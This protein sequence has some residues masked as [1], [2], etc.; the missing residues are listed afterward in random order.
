MDGRTRAAR[1]ET[2]VRETRTRRMC[3]LLDAAAAAGVILV[4]EYARGPEG[5]VPYLR[6]ESGQTI[7]VLELGQYAVRPHGPVTVHP[8]VVIKHLTA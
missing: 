3:A 1:D 7:E 6:H 4:T 2:A 8:D 5:I